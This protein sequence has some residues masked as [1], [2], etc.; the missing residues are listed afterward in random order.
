MITDAHSN[1]LRNG[2]VL[3]YVGVFW[4]KKMGRGWNAEC[5]SLC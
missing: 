5:L 2:M 3:E 1:K 4:K